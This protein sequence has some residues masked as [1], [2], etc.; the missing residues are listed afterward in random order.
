V[1]HAP[2]G[3][4]VERTARGRDT[5]RGIA[6]KV[7]RSR[8]GVKASAVRG[9]TIRV[10]RAEENGMSVARGTVAAVKADRVDSVGDT[11]PVPLVVRVAHGASASGP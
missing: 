2:I 3:A 1:K 10:A 6:P 7:M 11:N 5:D 4:K 8:A 9:G